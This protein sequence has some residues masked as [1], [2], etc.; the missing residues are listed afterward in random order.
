MRAIVIY[1][2]SSLPVSL[3]DRRARLGLKLLAETGKSGPE[4]GDGCGYDTAWW[5]MAW[6]VSSGKVVN[7][8]YF[9]FV[10]CSMSLILMIWAIHARCSYLVLVIS[11]V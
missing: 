2:T 8:L 4:L 7:R 10:S 6:T 11:E 9:S 1:Q 3:G 5:S